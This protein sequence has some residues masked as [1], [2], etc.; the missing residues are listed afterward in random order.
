MGVPSSPLPAGKAL[1][2]EY[3][4]VLVSVIMWL[5]NHAISILR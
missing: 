4:K 3:D 2:P 5:C 1:T